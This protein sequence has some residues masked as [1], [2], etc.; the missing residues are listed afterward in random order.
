MNG[1]ETHHGFCHVLHLGCPDLVMNLSEGL[2]IG[3]SD[4]IG[5]D[6]FL[7]SH[8]TL[9]RGITSTSSKRM[10]RLPPFR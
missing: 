3:C 2:A 4:D 5:H 7:A 9:N 8:V 1:F 6:L 10:S